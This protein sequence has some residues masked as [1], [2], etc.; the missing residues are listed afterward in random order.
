MYCDERVIR[1]PVQWRGNRYFSLATLLTAA[2]KK[3]GE[4]Y[5]EYQMQIA[6]LP[7]GNLVFEYGTTDPAI[8]IKEFTLMETLLLNYTARYEALNPYVARRRTVH[9]IQTLILKPE[10]EILAS[11]GQ[12]AHFH[13]IKTVAAVSL[14]ALI[15]Q[16]PFFFIPDGFLGSLGFDVDIFVP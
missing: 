11:Q 13:Y 6:P 15:I 9:G 5:Q 7:N 16:D 4:L 8:S 14:A 10:S 3:V 12:E 2:N 1:F